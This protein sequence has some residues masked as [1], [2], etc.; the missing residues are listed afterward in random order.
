MD[1]SRY[2]IRTFNTYQ[3]TCYDIYAPVPAG[4][5]THIDITH[6]LH[7]VS[8]INK[9]W[10][11]VD[12][13]VTFRNDYGIPVRFEIQDQSQAGQP[14]A[15]DYDIEGLTLFIGWKNAAEC[16]RR[17]EVLNGDRHTGY[18]QLD[19]DME[20]FL[21]QTKY[22]TREDKRE[23]RTSHS[24]FEDLSK[25][26]ANY[27]GIKIDFLSEIKK[28]YPNLNNVPLLYTYSPDTDHT[29]L[30]YGLPA[31]TSFTKK[32]SINIP[33]NEIPALRYFKEFPGCFGPLTLKLTF[34]SSAMIY[35]MD[36]KPGKEVTTIGS[37]FYQFGVKYN[38]YEG[39]ATVDAAKSSYESKYGE[40]ALLISSLKVTSLSCD[41]EGYNISAEGKA[42]LS[43]EFNIDQPYI[44][45][46]LY[47]YFKMYDGKIHGGIF[48]I[49]F[50]QAI[51]NLK[52][53][54]L[55]F[56]TNSSQ[57]T[58]FMNPMLR[59]LQMKVHNVLYPRVSVNTYD[60]RFYKFQINGFDPDKDYSNSLLEL[61]ND[62]N[63]D[64]AK[65]IDNATTDDTAFVVTIPME[66]D[67]EP[68]A[69]DGYESGEE[70]IN[71][72]LLGRVYT[73]DTSKNVYGMRYKQQNVTHEEPSPFIWF[74]TKTFWTADTTNG[75]T[76]HMNEVPNY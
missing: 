19:N 72:Q 65:I 2:G 43:Q 12:F 37:R 59:N 46:C 57:R 7:D 51:R 38:Q 28:I 16:I 6:K 69:F 63:N 35:S 27:C 25:P 32:I 14:P 34:D 58:T 71:F 31:N 75:L 10:L 76:F 55:A 29:E 68:N 60:S 42:A 48:D 30:A 61:P 41:I 73:T 62:L 50:T 23:N 17:V 66:R 67:N 9:S 15:D 47:T 24:I 20:T 70:N 21:T 18:T 4:T 33:L 40:G 52:D 36:I 39:A 3:N 22:V 74:T 54:H 45:P 44:I 1:T 56:P 11:N 64:D 5:P 53:I 26:Y 8:L 13:E 49:E